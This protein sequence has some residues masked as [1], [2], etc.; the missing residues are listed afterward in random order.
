MKYTKE[1]KQFREKY[2]KTVKV[3]L[4]TEKLQQENYIDRV[5]IVGRRERND[6]EKANIVKEFKNR[7]ELGL[8]SNLRFW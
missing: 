3:K 5:I 7:N 2:L 1:E 6:E 8:H 4:E